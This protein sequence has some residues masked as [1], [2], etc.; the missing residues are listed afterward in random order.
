MEGDSK[1]GRGAERKKNDTTTP[2]V[3]IAPPREAGR[4]MSATSRVFL[5]EQ[6]RSDQIRTAGEK[7]AESMSTT[8]R[9]APCFSLPSLPSLPFLYLYYAYGVH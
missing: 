1:R 9:D 3:E 8:R 4:R 5:T 7:D 2:T 6:S